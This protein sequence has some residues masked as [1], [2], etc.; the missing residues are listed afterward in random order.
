MELVQTKVV[1]NG[2]QKFFRNENMPME[3][4]TLNILKNHKK[5]CILK[6]YYYRRKYVYF[7]INETHAFTVPTSISSI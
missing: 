7:C 3:L 2:K 1:Q 4:C 5:H 6:L